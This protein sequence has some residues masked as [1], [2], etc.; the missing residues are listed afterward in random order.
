MDWIKTSRIIF[1]VT[2]IAIGAVGLI[3]GAFA[4]I[5][6]PVP[7]TFPARELLA[8]LTSLVTLASGCGLLVK[9]TA[10]PA[11]L[12]LLVLL[13]VWTLLFKGPPVVREPL[14]EGVYQSLGENAVVIAGAW[15]LFAQSNGRGFGLRSHLHGLARAQGRQ[16]CNAWQRNDQ[17]APG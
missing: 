7:K 8:Y 16:G 14:V 12:A 3:G 9:R 5:W 17:G 13:V 2:M 4:P 1:A 11:A 6:L 15:V 10:A